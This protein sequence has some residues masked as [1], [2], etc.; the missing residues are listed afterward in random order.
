MV[1]ENQYLYIIAA[2]TILAISIGLL[3]KF[4]YQKAIFDKVSSISENFK[5]LKQLNQSTAFEEIPRK[6]YSASWPTKSYKSFQKIQGSDVITYHVEQNIECLRDNIEIA[7][8]NKSKYDAYLHEVNAL[9]KLTD[10]ALLSQKN[11]S[12]KKFNK[13]EQKLIHKTIYRKPYLMRFKLM[14]YYESPKG[15][16]FYK[17]NGT[18]TQD[19]LFMVYSAWQQKK[20]YE[21]SARFERSLMS[22]SLR[23]DILKRDHFRCCICGISAQDGAKLHVDHIIPVSKG[24][25][26]VKS[27]LRT[28]CERCN[29]GKSNKL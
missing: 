21:K 13:Y 12:R 1:S 14:I 7:V 6:T 17:K 28:L 15:R 24:G 27:N 23:Y 11:L 19:H 5:T 26:T 20:S 16:N 25:K 2:A 9:D 22:D 3:I 8:R 4:I 18:F 10:D 29:L